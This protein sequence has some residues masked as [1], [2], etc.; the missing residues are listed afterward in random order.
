L[1]VRPL[2]CICHLVLS[3]GN[4][5]AFLVQDRILVDV[6]VVVA[7]NVLIVGGTR[8]SGVALWK[9]LFDNHGKTTTPRPTPE[10][11]EANFIKGDRQDAE[12]LRQNVALRNTTLFTT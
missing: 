9:E 12:Q 7:H 1:W 11:S 4:Y 2:S 3:N 8:F 6:V 5:H 10:E